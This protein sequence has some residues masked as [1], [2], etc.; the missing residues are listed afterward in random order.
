MARRKSGPKHP[1]LPNGFGRITL[2][3]NPNLRKP[4][5]AMITVGKNEEGSPIGKV[6]GYYTDWYAA[7]DA[8]SEYHKNPYDLNKDELTVGGLYDKWSAGYFRELTSL[9]SIRTVESAWSYVP[10]SFRKLNAASIKPQA[11][12]DFIS[13]DAYKK[14]ASGQITKPSA[15]MQA[16]LKSMFNLMYDYAV[17]SDLVSVNPARQF[18]LKGIQGKVEKTRKNKKALTYEQEQLLWSDQE[19]DLTRLILFNIYSGWRP[20][21]MLLLKKSDIDL[22]QMTMIGGMKTDAGTD[23]LV[24]VHSKIQEILRYYYEKSKGEYL[25]YDYNK[26]TPERISYDKYRGRFKKIMDRHGFKDYSPSC[27]RHTFASRAKQCKM[28]DMARQAIMGHVIS[29]VTDKHYTHMDMA[30]FLRKEIENI[31]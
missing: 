24:P 31:K 1:R 29:S 3:K 10:Q 18:S 7:Y 8:L 12:K 15:N 2:L 26:K 21:E 17:L 20:Q 23:R 4:Y 9:T 28:D 11:L 22:E 19:Y 6:L 13:F 16:R 25:F 27:P 30:D 5:R 14:D